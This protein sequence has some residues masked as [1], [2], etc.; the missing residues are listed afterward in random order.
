MAYYRKCNLCGANLDPNEKC[1]CTDEKQARDFTDSGQTREVKR[2]LFI[3][4]PEY[5]APNKNRSMVFAH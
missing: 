3:F 5:V 4:K 2:E 1:D